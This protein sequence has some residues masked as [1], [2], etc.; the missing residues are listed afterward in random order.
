ML[1][2]VLREKA[3]KSGKTIIGCKWVF[4]LK[5]K[6]DSLKRYKARI[7]SE[8]YMQVPCIDYTERYLPISCNFTTR[9]ALTITLM[10]AKN[11]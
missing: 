4:K 1:E 3:N 11:K 7:V 9:I 8:G 6:I 10:K 5:N 2:F